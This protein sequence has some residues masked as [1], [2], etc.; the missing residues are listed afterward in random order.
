MTG[1]RLSVDMDRAVV[2]LHRFAGFVAAHPGLPELVSVRVMWSHLA[3]DWEVEAQLSIHAVGTVDAWAMALDDAAVI[4][5]HADGHDTGPRL[6]REACGSAHGVA[7][8]VWQRVPVD[9]AS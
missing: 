6:H 2:V 8:S 1:G 9:G 3:R 7:V 5:R 4:V